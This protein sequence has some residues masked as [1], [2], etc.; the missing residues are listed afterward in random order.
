MQKDVIG[1][2]VI[3]TDT[4][5]TTEYLHVNNCGI[6][7]IWDNDTHTVREN[8]RSDWHILYITSGKCCINKNGKKIPV[9]EGNIAVFHPGE[10]QEYDFLA[11]DKSVSLWLH[12]CGTGSDLYMRSLDLYDKSVYFVGKNPEILHTFDCMVNTMAMQGRH[13]KMLC[14]SYLHLLLALFARN[15]VLDRGDIKKN[16][17]IANAINYIHR[18]YK[19][20]ITASELSKLCFLSVS[21]FE[22]LF[23]EI[24][25]S[26]F[27]GY[28]YKLR[29]ENAVRLLRN[30][31]LNTQQIAGEVGFPDANFFSRIFKKHMG[32]TPTAYRKSI[33][34]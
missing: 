29:I 9:E 16:S 15:A 19:E 18:N 23:K 14:D 10:R 21:R 27:L 34:K 17:T 31:D 32:Q 5:D 24:T 8:G 25:G 33:G 20:K 26:T 1:V 2:D 13:N 30:T 3:S 28:I 7:Y 22:H 12:F 4:D 6:Q 11:K